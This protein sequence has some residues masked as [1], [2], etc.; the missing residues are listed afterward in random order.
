[1]AQREEGSES[2]AE[3]D[4]VV[5][6]DDGFRERVLVRVQTR[7][8]LGEDRVR[9]AG[10][11][12]AVEFE[13]LGEERENECERYLECWLAGVDGDTRAMTYQIKQQRNE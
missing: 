4:N 5:A 2:S 3:Q 8:D 10:L 11:V 12:V 1:M 6:G 7:E 13:E 9:V